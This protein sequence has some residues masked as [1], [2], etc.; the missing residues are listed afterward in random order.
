MGTSLVTARPTTSLRPSWRSI[1]CSPDV[2]VSLNTG[3]KLIARF[4]ERERPQHRLSFG[5]GLG[6]FVCGIGIG[7][8]AGAGL[9]DDAILEHERRP[10]RDRGVETRRTPADVSDCTGVRSPALRLQLIDDFHR[11]HLRR[12]TDGPRGE[13]GAEDVERIVP[14]TQSPA[15]FA[16]EMLHVRVAL[17]LERLRDTHRT[18]TRHPA[19]VV[20]AEVDERSEEH[21]SEL[22]SLAYLVC[23]LLLEKKKK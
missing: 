22:Q 8:D 10:N 23:R 20:A 12:A 1:D 13:A 2:L 9:H 16:D 6:E 19:H 11:A 14:G 21:T 17:D 15:D 7:D 18:V 4:G 5:F 3:P